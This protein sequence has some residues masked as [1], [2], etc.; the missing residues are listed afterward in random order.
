MPTASRPSNPASARPVASVSADEGSIAARMRK[1]GQA[2]ER[3]LRMPMAGSGGPTINPGSFADEFTPIAPFM[4]DALSIRIRSFKTEHADAVRMLYEEGLLGGQ[5][6]EN[7]TAL[8]ID[9]VDFAYMTSPG[10]H[11][12]VALDDASDVVGTIGVQSHEEGVGEIRRLRV[13]PDCRRQG[14]GSKLLEQAIRFCRTSNF[15]KI[16]L[17]THME[18]E[19]AIKL[20][21]KFRFRH[22]KTRASNGKEMLVFYLDL[23]SDDA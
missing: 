14:V 22:G 16:M 4:P 1:R 21:E 15:L 7:D 13:R 11:F 20:F 23:Y 17:D 18:R 12:W 2:G 5:L 8:D 19:P 3:M 6:A 9:D 10:S